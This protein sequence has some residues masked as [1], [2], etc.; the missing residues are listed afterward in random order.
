MMKR[1]NV[2]AVAFLTSFSASALELFENPFEFAEDIKTAVLENDSHKLGALFINPTFVTLELRN[3]V[4]KKIFP[5]LVKTKRIYIKAGQTKREASGIIYFL[6][7]DKRESTRAIFPFRDYVA[8]RFKQVNSSLYL[9][10]NF[11]FLET[12]TRVPPP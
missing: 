3:E 10:E 7:Y 11:C 2:L 4:K 8:C 6:I 9:D 1:V 12:D 5:I